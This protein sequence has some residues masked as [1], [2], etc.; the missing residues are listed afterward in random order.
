MVLNI[1]MIIKKGKFNR[2]PQTLLITKRG[3][4]NA[5]KSIAEKF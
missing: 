4:S 5:K 1:D 3:L 2:N